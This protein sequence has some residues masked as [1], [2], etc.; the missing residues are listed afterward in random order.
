MIGLPGGSSGEG[1]ASLVS[2]LFV[3]VVT[4][5]VLAGLVWFLFYAVPS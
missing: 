5:A 2:L 1:P 4:A 3:V